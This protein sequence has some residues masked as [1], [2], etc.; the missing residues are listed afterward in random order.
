MKVAL[1]FDA[2]H[3]DRPAGSPGNL[4][5]ILDILGET[6]ATFFI[7]GRWAS[8]YQDYAHEIAG[9]GFT[10]GSHGY[11]HVPTHMLIP[12]AFHSDLSTAADAIYETTGIYPKLFRPPYGLHTEVGDHILAA[13]GYTRVQWDVNSEDYR[14]AP[15]AVVAKVLG[16]LIENPGVGRMPMDED[17]EVTQTILMHTWPDATVAAL[18]EI[19]SRLSEAELV[20]L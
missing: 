19:L 12:A 9:R 15:D 8:A 5:R 1:T 11:Y 10:I 16:E 6:P 20:K 17:Q 3:Q 18:P 2:E 4:P 7:Q 14:L 13:R